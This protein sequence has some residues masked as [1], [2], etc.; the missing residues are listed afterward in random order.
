MVKGLSIVSPWPALFIE[1]TNTLVVADLHIGLEDEREIKGVHI[2]T[3]LLPKILNAIINPVKETG[4]SRL[5]I[6]GDVKHEFGKPTEAE[7]WGVKRLFKALREVGCEIEVVKGNHDNYIIYI[8][9][10]LGI[11][12]HRSSLLIDR[13]LI[14]HGHE[15]LQ[16]D[17]KRMKQIIIGHEH[18]VIAIKDDVGVK[19]RFKAFLHGKLGNKV[20]TVLPSISPLAY[21]TDIN[22]VPVQEL[23]SPI[24]REAGI[25]DLIPYAIEIGVVVKSFPKLKLLM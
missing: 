5:V 21:G 24:L 9:K 15:P 14:K 23:L 6:A 8:L 7:W 20:I 12:L 18:P 13:F 2:P 19:H 17:E 3:T 11:K 1:R 4:C 16:D 22:E 25:D 10:E